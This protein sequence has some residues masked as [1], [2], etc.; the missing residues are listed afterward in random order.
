MKRNMHA[1]KMLLLAL[2]VLVLPGHR[3]QADPYRFLQEDDWIFGELLL[4][5]QY[6][7]PPD[8]ACRRYRHCRKVGRRWVCSRWLEQKPQR[9]T[10]ARP[11]HRR[12]GRTASGLRR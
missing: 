10:T 3:V 2:L 9:R 5:C 6:R 4:P 8:P 12:H 1:P 7:S 11:R